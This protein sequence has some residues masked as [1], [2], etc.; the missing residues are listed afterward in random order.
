LGNADELSGQGNSPWSFD[1]G[2]SHLR[3][4]FAKSYGIYGWDYTLEKYVKCDAA[5]PNNMPVTCGYPS[6]QISALRLDVLYLPPDNLWAAEVGYSI[7]EEYDIT[8]CGLD[9]FKYS[10]TSICDGFN[11]RR[12]A[13]KVNN[14]I[15]SGSKS[16]GITDNININ[17]SNFLTLQFYPSIDG[18][19][20]PL[21]TMRVD[22]GDGSYYQ[23]NQDLSNLAGQGLPIQTYF[24]V[25]QY[26]CTTDSDNYNADT[27][28]C[29]FKPRIQLRDNWGWCTGDV[30][31]CTASD[32]AAW[33]E[34]PGK[35]T[36]T[37]N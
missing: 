27:N 16:D 32:N 6:D 8:G 11:A 12:R 2:V 21:K 19:R 30:Y 3:Q 13:P 1:I 17:S 37:P 15:I 4:L 18:D 10:A 7:L 36:V 34:Y 9:D 5:Q 25:H 33:V 35:I 14:F 26:F 23:P 29:I 22:W 24:F 28:S 20:Q 31:K